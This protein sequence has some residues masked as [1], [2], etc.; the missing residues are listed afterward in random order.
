[1]VQYNWAA[2]NDDDFE[3]LCKELMRREGFRNVRR[4]SGPGSG[5]RGRDIHAEEFLSNHLP[6]TI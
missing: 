2:L 6:S 4:M 1:M 3:E 5:D